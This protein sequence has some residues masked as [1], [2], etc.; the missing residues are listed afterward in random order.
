VRRRWSNEL[1]LTFFSLELSGLGGCLGGF[2]GAFRPLLGG[3]LL[4]ASNST[5]S[6]QFGA[7]LL[8]YFL[9][10]GHKIITLLAGW[11]DLS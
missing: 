4:G 9:I 11:Q 3:E 6:C 7:G 1:L 8:Q 10:H 2:F 5:E